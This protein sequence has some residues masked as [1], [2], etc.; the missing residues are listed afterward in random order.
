MQYEL[1]NVFYNV[2][3]NV[4]HIIKGENKVGNKVSDYRL[5]SNGKILY[6]ATSSYGLLCCIVHKLIFHP[7]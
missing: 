4:K 1:F 6:N 3:S 7:R 2:L 5:N